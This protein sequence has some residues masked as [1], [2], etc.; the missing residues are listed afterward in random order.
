MKRIFS[1]RIVLA[2]FGAVSL[3]AVSVRADT[4]ALWTFEAGQNSA[5]ASS[6]SVTGTTL[7]SI[8]SDVGVGFA[9]GYHATAASVWSSPAGDATAAGPQLRAL[10][11]NNWLQG[12][13]YFQF[14]VSPD[15][16]NNSYS[17]IGL[18]WDQ[19]GS[20]TGPGTWGLYYSTDGITFAQFGSDY[21][22]VNGSWNTTTISPSHES[23]DLSAITAL[24]SAATI[25]FR[26]VDDSPAT[27][28]SITLGNVGTGG[29]GRIDNFSVTA[30]VTPI[31]EPASITLVCG[32]GS[33]LAW[34]LI[35]RK[36]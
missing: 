26:I 29:T 20:N 24:N 16:A 21:V 32:L 25:Y 30:N 23:V 28:G 34:N 8:P 33:L 17:G 10:S 4:I 22:I 31:P 12:S 9:S 14:T 2:A 11:A 6:F 18:T 7:G 35:R 15:L 27:G 36:R 19:T 3:A 13:D 1:I 5:L